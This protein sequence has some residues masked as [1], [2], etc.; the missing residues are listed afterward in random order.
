MKKAACAARIIALNVFVRW[1]ADHVN[2]VVRL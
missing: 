2:N 1:I